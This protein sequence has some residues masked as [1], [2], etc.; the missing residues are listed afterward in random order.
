MPSP[1]GREMESEGIHCEAAVNVAA[2]LA[3]PSAIQRARCPAKT[4]AVVADELNI[5]V[6]SIAP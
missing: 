6:G 5:Q 1:I 2:C 3:A 4:S